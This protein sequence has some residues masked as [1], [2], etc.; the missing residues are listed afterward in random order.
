[1]D[2]WLLRVPLVGGLMASYNAARFSST[3]ALLD[4]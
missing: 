3:L 1:M 4:G 2:A